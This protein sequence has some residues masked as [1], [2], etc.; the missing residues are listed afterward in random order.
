MGKRINRT[1]R[2]WRWWV[3]LPTM[4]ILLPLAASEFALRALAIAVMWLADAWEASLNTLLKT[5]RLQK[6]MRWVRKGG[7]S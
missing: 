1:I 2:N 5:I 4:I 7:T 3:V 6:V